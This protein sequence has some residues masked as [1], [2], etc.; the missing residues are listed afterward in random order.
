MT[1]HQPL[2]QRVAV[3]E[4]QLT[5]ILKI[6]GLSVEDWV[7]PNNAEKL[8]SMGRE[9]IRELVEKAET[10][11]KE[12]RPCTLQLGTHYRFV[13]PGKK[14]QINWQQWGEFLA[15]PPEQWEGLE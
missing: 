13:P 11:R 12:E 7:S 6:T 10:A 8:V 4:A 9:T 14:V 2:H 15:M 1:A 5:A 3:L